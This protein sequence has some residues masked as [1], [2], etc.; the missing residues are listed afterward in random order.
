MTLFYSVRYNTELQ[1]QSA[2]DAGWWY[3]YTV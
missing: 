2:L 3:C 1:A